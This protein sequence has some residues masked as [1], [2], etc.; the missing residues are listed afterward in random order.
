MEAVRTLN[1]A[2]EAREMAGPGHG[3]AGAQHAEAIGREL[4]LAAEELLDLG[5]AAR[6][7]DVGKILVPEPVLNKEEKLSRGDRALIESH[8]ELGAR[9]LEIV[10]GSTRMSSYVRHHHERF[11]GT[12]YPQKLRGEDIPVDGRII[13][14]AVTVAH[15]SSAAP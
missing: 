4:G 12:G 7:H 8:P 14:V 15:I 10:P 11:D 9:I 2:A 6:L 1:Q 5:Q 13:A 3:E